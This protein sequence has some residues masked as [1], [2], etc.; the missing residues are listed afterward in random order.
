[1]AKQTKRSELMDRIYDFVD[2]SVK[3][4][5]KGSLPPE[6]AQNVEWCKERALAKMIACID[7]I[8][9]LKRI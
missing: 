8:E 1:M 4:S 6:Q 7:S 5:W 2:A 9:G 3:D